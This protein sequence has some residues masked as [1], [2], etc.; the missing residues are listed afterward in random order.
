MR[1]SVDLPAPGGGRAGSP[2]LTFSGPRCDQFV[3]A[4]LIALSCGRKIPFCQFGQSS[5]QIIRLL[6]ADYQSITVFLYRDDIG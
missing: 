5:A 4:V 3:R 2:V 1:M 6:C